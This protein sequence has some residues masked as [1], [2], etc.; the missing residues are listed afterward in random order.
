MG[1]TAVSAWS[2]LTFAEEL[3][4]SRRSLRGPWTYKKAGLFKKIKSNQTKRSVGAQQ[5]QLPNVRE[6]CT[7]PRLNKACAQHSTKHA[8]LRHTALSARSSLIFQTG[9]GPSSYQE[10]NENVRERRARP[11]PKK[12]CEQHSIK[13]SILGH[14]SLSGWSWLIFRTGLGPSRKRC[15]DSCGKKTIE[16]TK[17][18][19]A[20]PTLT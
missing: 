17:E 1:H 8:I 3:C 9:L 4:L 14:T 7:R 15:W 13:H 5:S 12:A 11:A 2:M 6:R 10:K 20:K 16:N 19:R 18:R